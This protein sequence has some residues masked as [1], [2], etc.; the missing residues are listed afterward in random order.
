MAFLKVFQNNIFDSDLFSINQTL[1]KTFQ[2]SLFDSDLFQQAPTSITYIRNPFQTNIFQKTYNS[3]L[4]FQ[5]QY[6]QISY[7]TIAK[8]FQTNVFDVDI[9]QQP[10]TINVYPRKVFQSNIFQNILFQTTQIA[11]AGNYLFQ[12]GLFQGNVFDVPNLIVKTIQEIIGVAETTPKALGFPRITYDSV[13]L[14]MAV[15]KVMGKTKSKQDLER[16]NELFYHTRARS[17]PLQDAEN[18]VEFIVYNKTTDTTFV[19]KVFQSNIFQSNVFQFKYKRV[20]ETVSK[21]F[22]TNVFQQNIFQKSSKAQSVPTVFSSIFD[23]KVFQSSYDK[24]T[25]NKSVFQSG[26]FQVGLFH[27]TIQKFREERDNISISESVSYAKGRPQSITENVGITEQNNYIENAT[28]RELTETV[29]DTVSLSE[30]TKP[31]V[32]KLKTIT[33]TLLVNETIIG[34]SARDP[35]IVAK[36]FQTNVF[37]QDVFQKRYL[38]KVT[39]VGKVFQ[40]NIFQSI[41]QQA[42]N[43]QTVGKL[44]QNNV[45][46]TKIF[47][48]DSF[49]KSVLGKIQTIFQVGVFQSTAFQTKVPIPKAAPLDTVVITETTSTRRIRDNFKAINETVGITDTPTKVEGFVKTV[50]EVE[51]IT[52]IL[53]KVFGIVRIGSDIVN[54]NETV[55]YKKH[56][57]I[58]ETIN[59]SETVVRTRS[60]VRVVNENV[61]V[62][63]YRFK[64]FNRVRV[65]NENI[66][67]NESVTFPWFKNIPEVENINELVVRARTIL[68]TLSD[69]ISINESGQPKHYAITS[70]YIDKVFQSNVFDNK[71]F[72]QRYDKNVVKPIIFQSNVFQS[73]IFQQKLQP[74]ERTVGSIFQTN[75]FASNVFQKTFDKTAPLNRLFQRNIFQSSI[76]QA[77]FQLST[78]VNK[79]FQTNIF[80]NKVFQTK[81]F[82]TSIT[83]KRPVFSGIYQYPLFQA[84]EPIKKFVEETENISEALR[85]VFGSS[86]RPSDIVNVSESLSRAREL[87]RSVTDSVNVTDTIPIFKQRT[88][89]IALTETVGINEETVIKDRQ[90]QYYVNKVFQTNIFDQDIF[91]KRWNQHRIIPKLFQTN[92]FDSDVFQQTFNKFT[93][94]AVFQSNVFAGKFWQK[95]YD[96][97]KLGKFVFQPYVFDSNVYQAPISKKEVV[98]DTVGITDA[99]SIVK[100]FVKLLTDVVGISENVSVL[101][102]RTIAKSVT[103][104]VNISEINNRA[105]PLV[106]TVSDIVNV[107]DFTKHFKEQVIFTIPRIFQTNVFDNDVFQQLWDPSSTTIKKLFQTNIF[108]QDIFQKTF[109]TEFKPAVFQSNVF[110]NKVFTTKIFNILKKSTVV[111]QSFVFQ[112]NTFQSAVGRSKT[113]YDTVGITDASVKVKGFVKA[114]TDSVGIAESV[115]S[116]VRKTLTKS[117]TDS[118]SLSETLARATP[119]SVTL[120]ES[121]IVKDIYSD[122][123]KKQTIFTIPR[124]FQ[125]NVFDNDV[126]QQ[127]WDPS[128]TSITKVFQTN[129]FDSDVFQT[130]TFD[131]SIKPAV[132]DSDVFNNK[133]SLQN[134][135]I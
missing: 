100:G 5:K 88:W 133:Y 129:I 97:R 84:P 14:V 61:S 24:T 126:F 9:F 68:R 101:K 96:T 59:T 86:Q 6:T 54:V 90:V 119:K 120:T 38:K 37:D 127:L 116:V 33:D 13:Q 65:V 27:Q 82:D 118:V 114:V 93:V 8:L 34:E 11:N 89:K 30:T 18:I 104:S 69:S 132:F 36:L 62:T 55:A 53:T 29:T 60:I 121:V 63:E 52:D 113:V 111:F 94:P 45:F 12:A 23:N 70:S 47:Q 49:L 85:V 3:K 1:G 2:G 44:F 10:H 122:I 115:N 41:F 102:Q 56:K 50:N 80:Q 39:S 105:V 107:L 31:S 83:L 66:S 4:L 25:V 67:I 103:E 79:V 135:L 35:N 76:F 21:V 28:G 109:N 32:G 40:T 92:V 134:R 78:T 73:D 108:D 98:Y 64:P 71:V 81:A 75:V 117:V 20:R 112:S 7:G 128:S 26:I 130:A 15:Y 17:K 124:V 99:S 74:L 72:Q 43:P 123:F 77:R 125:T 19:F 22:Q 87:V 91:Q 131:T 57:Q 16:I 106:R 51:G 58:D 110:N 46:S 95:G 42:S 48:S